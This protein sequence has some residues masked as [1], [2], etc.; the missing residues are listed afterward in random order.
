M[1]PYKKETEGERNERKMAYE[2]KTDAGSCYVTKLK[3]G[4]RDM[5]QG[6]QP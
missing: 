5:S 4:K 2:G 1:H 3:D 6:V